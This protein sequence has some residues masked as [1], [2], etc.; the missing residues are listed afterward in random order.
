MKTRVVIA[1][2]H[3]ML[4]EALVHVLQHEGDIEVV[5]QADNGRQA[6]EMARD[7]APDVLVMD[8]GMPDL[9]GVGATARIVARHPAIKVIALSAY[10]ERRF[11]SEMFRAGAAG[12][13]TKNAASTELLR[14]IRAVIKGDHY[15]CPELA[16]IL[17]EVPQPVKPEGLTVTEQPVL[18]R[19][20]KEVLQLIAEGL[21]GAEIARKL[22]LASST[23]EVHRR[24]IMRKLDL[25][26]IADLTRY[27][28]REGLT[29]L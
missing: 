19:R 11:V 15:V 8:I 25:H 4:R 22:N 10:S 1:D 20:E 6:V 5:G 3:S 18:G 21:R 24:N 27:A 9:N 23:V 7:L 29:S 13:V 28:I 17:V 12:Y 14:A 26:T 2:D 16:A